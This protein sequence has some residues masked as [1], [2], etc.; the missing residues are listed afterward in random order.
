MNAHLLTLPDNMYK[1]RKRLRRTFYKDDE[2]SDNDSVFAVSSPSD[3]PPPSPMSD[4]GDEFVRSPAYDP[5][6]HDDSPSSPLTD[7]PDFD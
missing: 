3:A 1:V 5:D 2:D 7:V 4:T 6:F